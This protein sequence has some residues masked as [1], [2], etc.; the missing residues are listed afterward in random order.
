MPGRVVVI[1]GPS[2]SGKTERLLVDYRQALRDRSGRQRA[3]DF[4]HASQRRRNSPAPDR[5][6]A[7]RLLSTGRDDLCTVCRDGAD[8]QRSGRATDFRSN[9]AADSAPPDQDRSPGRAIEIFRPDRR[10]HGPGRPGHRVHQRAEAARN[11]AEAFDEACA[12]SHLRRGK[13]QELVSLYRAYQQHLHDSQL[14]DAEGRFWTARDLLRLGQ[15]RPF[16]HL[17]H[18]AV[19]GFTDF[20]RPQHEILETVAHRV[21]MLQISLPSESGRDR[22][23][24]FAKSNGTRTEIQR[25]L[26][27]VTV[28]TLDRPARPAWPALAHIEQEL[29]K[30]PRLA[31]RAEDATGIEVSEAGRA[32]DELYLVGRRIK[33]LLVQGDGTSRR[34]VSPGEVAVVMRSPSGLLPLLRE[35]FDELGIPYALEDGYPLAQVPIAAALVA[36]LRLHVEDWPFRGLLHVLGNN[37]FRPRGRSRAGREL[38]RPPIVRFGRC[39]YR[40]A[41]PPY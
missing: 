36:V 35:A 40:A 4:S 30:S 14:Y 9:E 13:D 11:L 25:R 39:R 28:Q 37:Y 12:K 10:N 7:A 15:T 26:P 3:V 29:F 38:S 22:P 32:I 17:R 31:R 8:G 27:N 16:E 24:L 2:G 20:T 23:E 41:V 34:A 19:D 21:D 33:Q 18:V 5:R 1:A 6:R